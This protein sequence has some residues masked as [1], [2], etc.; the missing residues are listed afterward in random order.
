M[1]SAS[2]L[3]RVIR[4]FVTL[5]DIETVKTAKHGHISYVILMKSV[6]KMLH[7]CLHA[8]LMLKF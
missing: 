6:I 8:L 7:L 5:F 3:N 1:N 4:K 2:T